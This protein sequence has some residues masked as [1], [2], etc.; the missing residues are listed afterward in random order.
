MNQSQPQTL[1]MAV[2]LFYA[3]AVLNV[4]FGAV[5]NPLVF[6]ITV[7]EVAAG[8]GIA[9]EK[10]WGYKLGVAICV[11]ALLPF[12]ILGLTDGFTELLDPSL[13][14]ALI[15]PIARFALLVHPMS[16]NY[17]RIWFR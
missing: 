9:N 10:K 11:L 14:L 15:F 17:Q 1:Q 4:L 2:F 8:L 5:F 12:V 13:L 16:R 7:G 6:V 3:N